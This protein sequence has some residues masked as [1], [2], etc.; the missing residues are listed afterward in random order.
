MCSKNDGRNVPGVVENGKRK[1]KGGI[2]RGEKSE[3]EYNQGEMS[4]ETWTD[5]PGTWGLA[6]LMR[7]ATESR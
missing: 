2:V 4:S 1:F 5:S 3:G 6:V 7:D